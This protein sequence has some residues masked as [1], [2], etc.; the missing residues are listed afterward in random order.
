MIETHR[1]LLYPLSKDE[2]IRHIKTPDVFALQM[3]LQ[4]SSSLSENDVQDAILNDLLPNLADADKDPLFYT[5]WIVVEK[6]HRAII[7][8]F[9][10]HGEADANGVVEIGYGTDMNFRNRGYMTETVSAML[11][12]LGNNPSVKMVQART[13]ITNNASVRVL[14]KTGFT[15]ADRQ[16]DFLLLQTEVRHD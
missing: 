9:C 6:I 2:L 4:P 14:G 10:F 16:G 15:F 3:G 5:M 8:G 13:A 11:H 12:W 7:G 1:L